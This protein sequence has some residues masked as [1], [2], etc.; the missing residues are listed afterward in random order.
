[1]KNIVILISG[2]GSNMAAIVRA[3]QQQEWARRL[4]A[5]V[6]AVISNKVIVRTFFNHLIFCSLGKFSAFAEIIKSKVS[7]A[8]KLHCFSDKR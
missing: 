5:R 3:S 8:E 4:G 7:S 1:M 6:V 2:G